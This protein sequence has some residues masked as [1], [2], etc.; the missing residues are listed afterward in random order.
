V[1]AFWAVNAIACVA[2]VPPA[3]LGPVRQETPW[4][5]YLG[6]PRHDAAV[7]ESLNADPRPL[8][9]ADVG[10][11]VRGSPALGETVIAVGAADRVVAL[12][13]RATGQSLWHT[14]VAGTIQAG[15]LLESDRL[16]VA[17]EA[18]PEA[19]I[20]ALRLRDGQTIWSTKTESVV[21]P[22]ALDGDTLFAATETGLVLRLDADGGRVTWR[23]RLPGGAAVRA[24]P[25]PTRAGL[26]VATTTDTLFLL[27][28]ASGEIRGRLAIPG[29]VLATP[30][31]DGKRLYLGTTAGHVL[32]IA[33]PALTVAWDLPAGDA[34]YGAPAVARDT[35]YALAR[36]GTL[37]M[38]PADNVA[39]ARSFALDLTA[40]AGPMP[41]ASGVLVAGVRGDVLLVDRATGAA[42]WRLQLDG[43]IEQPPL[44]RDRQLVVIAGRGDIHSYR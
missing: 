6:T 37:W 42:V 44:V 19:K 15:P 26:A 20:Y 9:T 2:Y 4:L 5:A 33:L 36:N 30:A 22:L 32:A 41:I 27:D 1:A 40:T 38:V 29:A 43:P 21:A 39:A 12:V 7:A 8:W 11:A 31:F 13:D 24:G 25:V 34:V 18:T 23:H 10:R 14:R 17:T 16:Y 35:V 28:R 3:K